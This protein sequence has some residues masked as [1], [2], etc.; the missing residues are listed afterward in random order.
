[1]SNQGRLTA[2]RSVTFYGTPIGW[3][4]DTTEA[5]AYTV[6]LWFSCK[7]NMGRLFPLSLIF[8]ANLRQNVIQSGSAS[9]GLTHRELW[10]TVWLS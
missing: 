9:T 2:E 8:V 1:M 3:T 5:V 6:S 7:L 10:R 4:W